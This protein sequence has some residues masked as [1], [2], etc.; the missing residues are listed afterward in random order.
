MQSVYSKCAK[1]AI[2]AELQNGL[3][4]FIYWHVTESVQEAYTPA[5]I[6]LYQEEREVEAL[7][8]ERGSDVR[9]RALGRFISLLHHFHAARPRG[10]D[11]AQ[12]ALSHL[13]SV[14][15]HL[16]P[17]PPFTEFHYYRNDIDD[18]IAE[19]R[20]NSG[21]LAA[22]PDWHPRPKVAGN[23]QWNVEFKRALELTKT[24]YTD[25]CARFEHRFIL[26]TEADLELVQLFAQ[27]QLVELA[28]MHAAKPRHV[29]A[30]P[31]SAASA[32][33][34]TSSFW[35][36]RIGST[37]T[38]PSSPL[39]QFEET[40]LVQAG[41]QFRAA[42][43]DDVRTRQSL[44]VRVSEDGKD[45]TVVLSKALNPDTKPDR[46]IQRARQRYDPTQQIREVEDESHEEAAI[47]SAKDLI[48]SA[49]R[50]LSTRDGERNV[51]LR[52][53]AHNL[54]GHINLRLAELKPRSE[55]NYLSR[56]VADWTASI[57][58]DEDQP[59]IREQ[60]S[61][62]KARVQSGAKQDA[63]PSSDLATAD[64][65][66]Q[67]ASAA[68]TE[69]AAKTAET[70]PMNGKSSKTTESA[71]DA[72]VEGIAGKEREKTILES[73]FFGSDLVT[74]MM[75]DALLA[76]PFPHRALRE[77][78]RLPPAAAVAAASHDHVHMLERL[79]KAHQATTKALTSE[80]RAQLKHAVKTVSAVLALPDL[81]HVG[82]N[83]DSQ[84]RLRSTSL[85]LVLGTLFLLLND[86]VR[87]HGELDLISNA[88]K[89]NTRGEAKGGKKA[90]PDQDARTD[91][92]AGGSGGGA[93]EAKVE[94]MQT[95]VQGEALLL[96]A[97]TC[98]LTN[99]V[100][101][102]LKFFRW[103]VKWYA[104]QQAPN[105]DVEAELDEQIEQLERSVADLDMRWWDA[106]L[107]VD[108]K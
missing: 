66:A 60:L 67:D 107:V 75:V 77:T 35:N 5:S 89:P 25:A 87:A 73:P 52:I 74:G 53:D 72:Q 43:L 86:H 81:Q 2:F 27:D 26:G 31:P 49:L 64:G 30:P 13:L 55:S 4:P 22:D 103:F 7:V 20:Q 46:L 3:E 18:Y 69:Q 83:A 56:A 106:L 100:Q 54:R 59:E 12:D 40:H 96:L 23:Y 92:V 19:Q 91:A 15:E 97:K 94:E 101:E 29:P 11:E 85:R 42:C 70:A 68:P 58:L 78:L 50:I 105:A 93:E 88:L 14:F 79:A 28:S 16:S 1:A 32:A 51:S 61:G 6:G 24:A 9:D 33:P 62:A 90:K 102:A 10:N 44:G 80:N 45:I 82:R 108:K 21:L 99:K 98:W 38:A 41:R 104:D 71:K 84:I 63:A 95:R 34:S 17:P 36:Q 39:P 47:R 57:E 76:L 65:T 8:L 48:S 37:S